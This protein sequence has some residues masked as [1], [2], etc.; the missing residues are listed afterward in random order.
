MMAGNI[1]TQSLNDTATRRFASV[2]SGRYPAMRPSPHLRS[3][4]TTRGVMGHV[5]IALAPA[6]LGSV[7]FFG[8]RVLLIYLV[9]VGTA[10]C[11]D[12][13]VQLVK[14]RSV[15]RFDLSPIVTGVLLAVS[16]PAN[17]PLWFPAVGAVLGILI[18]KE[19]FGGIGFNFLNPALFGRAVLRLA[20]SD[21][22][23]QNPQPAPP[24]GLGAGVDAVAGPTPLMVLKQGGSLTGTQLLDS[25]TGNVAGKLGETSV[26][27][28]LIGVVW[29]LAFGIIWLRIPLAML[30]A[31]AVMAF[32]FGGPAGLFSAGWRVVLGHLIGGTSILGAFF[33]ATDYSSSPSSPLAQVLFGALCGVLIMLFR[34]FSPWSE[35]FTFA[36]LIANLAV[37]AM[38]RW[39]R[40]RVLGEGVKPKAPPA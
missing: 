16:L 27:L 31:I 37:P 39:I 40:P 23:M 18:A 6:V 35:G 19:L 9:S 5:L 15:S 24:F 4:R 3:P 8:F 7:Y 2:R 36:V 21:A 10:L 13:A 29:L 28:L 30:G 11:T 33:M 25:F 32:I 17:I 26:L 1:N 34:L 14:T 12:A 22:M 20:F 38:N